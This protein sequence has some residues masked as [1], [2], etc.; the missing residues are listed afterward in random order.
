[1]ADENI[2]DIEMWANGCFQYPIDSDGS[3]DA[4][5][6]YTLEKIKE[7]L[8]NTES[9]KCRIEIDYD[10]NKFIKMMYYQVLPDDLKEYMLKHGK[11]IR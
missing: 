11:K 5:I 8:T 10:R 9:K 4:Y 2:Q 7:M 1:M 6:K 3:R